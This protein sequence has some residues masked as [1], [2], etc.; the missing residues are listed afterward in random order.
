LTRLTVYNQFGSRRGLLEAVFDERG[1]WRAGWTDRRWM[2]CVTPRFD[3]RRGRDLLDSGAATMRSRAARWP[4]RATGI[5]PGAGGT[6]RPPHRPVRDIGRPPRLPAGADTR[7]L[8]DI[9]TALTSQSLFAMLAR[10]SAT[11]TLAMPS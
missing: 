5:R 10:G 8:V 6:P 3:P 9:L 1:R 11:M 2:R 7:E 4:P